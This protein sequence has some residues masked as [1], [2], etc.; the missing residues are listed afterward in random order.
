MNQGFDAGQKWATRKQL[1][2][3]YQVHTKTIDLWR[4]QGYLPAIMMGTRLVRFDI[5][6]CD[7]WITQF[8]HS[9]KWENQGG[10]K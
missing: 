4:R 3:R 9:A 5:S 6:A 2:A 8:R 7:T 1:A 10:A